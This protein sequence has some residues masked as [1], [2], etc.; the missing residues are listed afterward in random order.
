MVRK[1]PLIEELFEVVRRDI[2][3]IVHSEIENVKNY[4]GCKPARVYEE[5]DYLEFTTDY[6]IVA[7]LPATESFYVRKS[8]VRELSVN[9]EFYRDSNVYTVAR[10]L[11]WLITGY[12][13]CYC[14]VHIFTHRIKELAEAIIYDMQVEVERGE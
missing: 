3:D 12:D 13:D 1:D 14:D 8:R 5:M 7:D 10:V 4:F 11:V 9:I 2:E 6:G